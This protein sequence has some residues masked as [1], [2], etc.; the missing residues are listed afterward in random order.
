MAREKKSQEPLIDDTYVNVIASI[1]G[2]SASQ[3]DGVASVSYEAGLNGKNFNFGKNKRSNAIIVRIG[4]G[5]MVTIE[6]SVNVYYGRII[7]QVV[8]RL[9]EKI[10]EEVEKSTRYKVKNINVN[11]VGVV[12]AN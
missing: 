2:S 8:C 4:K 3:V 11:V 6:I 12:A 9:Q 7:P 5:E 10:K 1:A